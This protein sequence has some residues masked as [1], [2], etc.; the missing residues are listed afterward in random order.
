MREVEQ[1]H[2]GVRVFSL[3]HMD[4]QQRQ[5]YHIELGVKGPPDSVEAAFAQLEAGVAALA[6]ELGAGRWEHMLQS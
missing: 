5:A 2:P 1:A 6:S 3:P 4:L